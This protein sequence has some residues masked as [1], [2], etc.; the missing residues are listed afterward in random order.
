MEQNQNTSLFD[1]NMD[2][3][4]QSHILSISKWTRFIA[5]TGFVVGALALILFAA[6]GEQIFR[7]F[8]VLF[9]AGESN[10]AGAVIV[11]AVL[12]LA[13]VACWLFFLIKSSNLLRKG[14]ESRNSVTLAEGF[15]AMRMYFTFSFII[16]ILSMLGT[17]TSFF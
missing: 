15:R 16:S 6:Y 13:L 5:I 11:V 10:L 3:Q 9:S 14:L 1:M 17:L 2:S 7:A 12:V 4:T 8:S